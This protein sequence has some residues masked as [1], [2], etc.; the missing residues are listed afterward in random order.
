[1]VLHL[2][3]KHQSVS[4]D[5]F[6]LSLFTHGTWH[7]EVNDGPQLTLYSTNLLCRAESRA[8]QRSYISK[9]AAVRR[10]R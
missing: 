10:C 2:E 9:L 5:E 8:Y 7:A 1:M 4:V 6:D 3:Q